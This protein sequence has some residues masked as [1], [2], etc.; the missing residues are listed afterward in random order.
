M[1]YQ[2]VLKIRLAEIENDLL[3]QQTLLA[4]SQ[5]E[6]VFSRKG[7]KGDY[8]YFKRSCSNGSGH[9]ASGPSEIYLGKNYDAAY[10]IA[11]G[12]LAQKR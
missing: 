11:S 4:N 7:R 8:V 2:Q 6:T 3:Y 9:D 5:N 12:M 1:D 10:R